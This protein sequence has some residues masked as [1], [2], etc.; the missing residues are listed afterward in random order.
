MLMT[1]FSLK[2]PKA[3]ATRANKSRELAF[4][5]F[6]KSGTIICLRYDESGI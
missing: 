3:T 6:I 2:M 4:K 1:S 5:N